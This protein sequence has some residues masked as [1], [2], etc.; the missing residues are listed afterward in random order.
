MTAARPVAEV[1]ERAIAWALARRG[2]PRYAGRC[3][4]F[5]EDAY[6][7]ANEIEV[8]GGSSATESATLYGLWDLE[9]A[10]PR[11]ALVFYATHG[12]VSGEIRDWGHVG[13]SLGDG[14]IVHAWDVVRI[15]PVDAVGDLVPPDGWTPA[16]PLGWTPVER[17]LEG[18]R[19]RAWPDA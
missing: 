12:P 13:L 7:R 3:L 15:D 4:S 19:P 17:V 16:E 6:E 2:S 14:A 8:F 18:S 9:G 10:P 11:G 5:V 1:V